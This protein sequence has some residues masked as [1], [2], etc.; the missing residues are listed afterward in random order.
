MSYPIHV[1]NTFASDATILVTQIHVDLGQ[2]VRRGDLLATLTIKTSDESLTFPLSSQRNGWVCYRAVKAGTEVTMGQLLFLLNTAVIEEY[3][4]DSQEC[5]QETELGVSGRRHLERELF[6][7]EGCRFNGPLFESTQ[8]HVDQMGHM[9][10]SHPL[11]SNSKEGVPPKMAAALHPT[12]LEKYIDNHPELAKRLSPALQKS[13][14]L[15]H[16]PS[17]APTLNR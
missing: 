2:R 15:E 9:P 12:T 3:W 13:L 16:A 6:R 5:N 10:P 14:H 11:L 7:K 17:S 8:A 1:P 4:T